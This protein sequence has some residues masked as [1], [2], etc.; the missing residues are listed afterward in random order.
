MVLWRCSHVHIL[1]PTSPTKGHGWHLV[2]GKL[3]H[4]WFDGDSVPQR[5]VD[6]LPD[7]DEEDDDSDSEFEDAVNEVSYSIGDEG[8]VYW[9]GGEAAN[10][11]EFQK[12]PEIFFKLSYTCVTNTK[13]LLNYVQ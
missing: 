11:P 7:E 5:M 13:Q 4:L 12:L 9:G 1:D 10:L 6:H 8:G 3:E 2:E